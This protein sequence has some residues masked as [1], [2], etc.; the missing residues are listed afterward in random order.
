[1]RTCEIR[2]AMS[3]F[4]SDA[5]SARVKV[6]DRT[7]AFD[8]LQHAINEGDLEVPFSGSPLTAF[9]KFEDTPITYSFSLHHQEG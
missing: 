8:A 2:L 3:R 7:S 5:A 6:E 9:V 1:M 4:S